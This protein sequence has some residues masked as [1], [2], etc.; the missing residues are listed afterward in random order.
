MLKKITSY[1]KNN[2]TAKDIAWTY[3][4]NDDYIVLRPNIS[5]EDNDYYNALINV[6]SIDKEEN[7][8]KISLEELYE[9]YY[10][11]D[12][13]FEYKEDYKIFNLPEMFNGEL[14]VV[15][16]GNYYQDKKVE[17]I[18][19]FKNDEGYYQILNNKIVF[20]QISD[21][22]YVLPMNISTFLEHLDF[23]NKNNSHDLSCQF[24]MLSRI[25]MAEL[26]NNSNTKIIL[27]NRLKT[28]ECPVIINKNIELDFNDDG[29]TMEVFP[30]LCSDEVLNKQL[31]SQ[32]YNNDEIQDVYITNNN[33]I[34]TRFAVENKEALRKLK[35]YRYTT[36]EERYDMILGKSQLFNTPESN[37][38]ECED[39]VFDLSKFGP[40]VNGIGY[41]KYRPIPSSKS[42]TSDLNWRDDEYPCITVMDSNGESSRKILEPKHLKVLE[43]ALKN[44]GDNNR[45]T[46]ELDI[47]GQPFKLILTKEQIE[48]EIENIKSFIIEIK[49]IKS[50]ENL[51]KIVQSYE[52]YKDEEFIR[53]KNRYIKKEPLEK[54]LD[55]IKVLED[56]AKNKKKNLLISDNFDG[57]DYGEDYDSANI[58]KEVIIPKSLKD[59]INLFDYQ[60]ECLL[61]LQNLYRTSKVNGF[62]LCD[63]MG[64]GK[65]LQL[66]SFLAWIKETE[67]EV[68]EGPTLIVAPT[69]LLKNWDSNAESSLEEGE[70]QKFFKEG[71]FK[72]L[73]VKGTYKDNPNELRNYDIVF[74][75]YDSL[76]LNESCFGQIKW[77]VIIC[78]E[79]QF[80]KTPSIRRTHAVKAQNANFKIACSATP[81][82]N[83]L[84]DLWSLVD[85]CKPG[86][87]GSLTE[88]NKMYVNRA[89][90]QKENINTELSQKLADFYIRREKDILPKVL[91]QKYIKIIKTTPNSLERKVIS[92]IVEADFNISSITKLICSSSMLDSVHIK[93]SLTK[94]NLDYILK[95]SSKLKILETI[96]KEISEKREK[97][98]IFTNYHKTQQIL[99][100]AINQ[101]FNIDP[102]L[103]NGEETN[104]NK[105]YLQLNKFKSKKGF[106]VAILAPSVAGFGLTITE[107]N[108]VVHY[109]RT[110]NPA[111]EDQ[112]TDRAYRIGQEK[113]VTV[114]YPMLSMTETNT[115][116][117]SDINDFIEENSVRALG[118]QLS[119]EEKLNI[120]ISRKKDM[121]LK[122]FLAV[123][124]SEE[125]FCKE[126]KDMD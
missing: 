19:Q 113:D 78:D 50:I 4:I 119:P 99:L 126:F 109:D 16:N 102:I 95:N 105:R 74:T 122:F 98:L 13:N 77:N 114:Y 64:L 25:R 11:F 69:V 43:Y 87:L 85:F 27:C 86:L 22:Y 108:H 41:F 26:M 7:L 97:V 39:S 104:Y 55:R 1:L 68:V 59:S 117:Y 80:I 84:C 107:A 75:T 28:E 118:K 5:I 96:L 83:S 60:K 33:G 123:N 46:V 9:L 48:N 40:R 10:D 70:I 18:P 63:D 42:N 45:I 49:D 90:N 30:R 65:T 116:T 100:Y 57:V 23:Y 54:I 20:S 3:T 8:L 92:D 103:L 17:Y 110:W 38:E 29:E 37:D 66:L 73:H 115:K 61:K 120:I 111:K 121:L 12:N 6:L 21:K 124:E 47:D 24:A 88:F 91:K 79:A 36:G 89:Q 106:G 81:I 53:F 58:I 34:I 82:E 72:T 56:K 15:N 2:L 31:L 52:L 35:K 67:G 101:W 32:I 94:E 125:D 76:R 44:I 14:H 71:T 112:A 62:M 51:K 93:G